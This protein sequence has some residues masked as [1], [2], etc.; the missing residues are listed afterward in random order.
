MNLVTVCKLARISNLPTVWSNVLCAMVLSQAQPSL[1]NALLVFVAMSLAY[2]G[3]MFL[4]DAVDA[5]W[6]KKNAPSRP[7]AR[8]E[9]ERKS[10]FIMALLCLVL[11]PIVLCFLEPDPGVNKTYALWSSLCLLF[12]IGL[13]NWCH[14]WFQYNSGLMGICRGMLYITTALALGDISWLF[15]FAVLSVVFYI[16]GLT[17]LARSEHLNIF[18]TDALSNL[19]FPSVSVL[20]LV[21]PLIYSIYVGYHFLLMWL[22]VS[23]LMFWIAWQIKQ[24]FLSET[25]NVKAGIGGLLAAIPLIDASLLASHNAAMEVLF[26]IGLFLIMPRLHQWVAGT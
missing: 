25:R 9:A 21:S 8:G 10:V 26:C 5:E 16:I 4:N 24:Y 12:F 19:N 15:L 13:Y 20:L 6:D 3:G 17:R 1:I 23:I 11:T 7:I 2:I 14:K 22:V 18:A